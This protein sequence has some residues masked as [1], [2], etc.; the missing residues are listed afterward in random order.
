[1]SYGQEDRAMPTE[2]IHVLD[3]F[4]SGMDY[5]V[6]GNEFTLMSQQ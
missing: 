2:K 6:V 3:M 1:M 5:R 4:Y